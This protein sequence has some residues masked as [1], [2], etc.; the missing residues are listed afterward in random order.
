[1]NIAATIT[2]MITNNNPFVNFFRNY[3]NIQLD[4]TG[5]VDIGA[6]A[7]NNIYTRFLGA[8]QRPMNDVLDSI[9]NNT[10]FN[11]VVYPGYYNGYINEFFIITDFNVNLHIGVFNIQLFQNNTWRNDMLL[12][13]IF[14]LPSAHNHISWAMI[15]FFIILATKFGTTIWDYN[16]LLYF[17]SYLHILDDYNF[18]SEPG[19]ANTQQEIQTFSSIRRVITN[20]RNRNCIGGNAVLVDQVFRGVAIPNPINITV[21]GA[22]AAARGLGAIPGG[23]GAVNHPNALAECNAAIVTR[24]RIENA[25]NVNRD[26]FLHK[27][28]AGDIYRR[29]SLLGGIDTWFV[30]ENM[31]LLKFRQNR[32]WTQLR[33][34]DIYD[35]YGV[36]H[37]TAIGQFKQDNGTGVQHNL[38]AGIPPNLM[39]LP[40]FSVSVGGTGALLITRHPYIEMLPTVSEPAAAAAIIATLP[41][42]AIAA[43]RSPFKALPA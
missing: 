9:N 21:A 4:A 15:H 1:M 13:H 11:N 17:H 43:N 36:P 31:G 16:I 24:R 28:A 32:D 14:D 33:Y 7:G 18:R 6:L 5:N 42:G 20:Y 29:P 38:V 40:N 23:I 27:N 25:L 22:I 39:M 30:T 37:N 8:L 19:V 2:G 41:P 34:I 12:G 35:Q 3:L 10:L 26:A